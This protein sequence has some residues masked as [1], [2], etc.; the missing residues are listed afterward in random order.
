MIYVKRHDTEK[1]VVL[2]MCDAALID[3]VLTEGDI[4]INIR[5]YAEFYK[6]ELVDG[7]L[8][9][10][11]ISS[12]G[13]YSANVIGEEAIGAAIEKEIIDRANVRSVGKVPYAQAFNTRI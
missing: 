6:G 13:L 12:E 5:D 9:R 10:S 4:E 11:L 7:K 1:G 8:A 2:A 3:R